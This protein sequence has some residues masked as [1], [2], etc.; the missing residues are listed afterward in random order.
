MR[1]RRNWSRLAALRATSRASRRLWQHCFTQLSRYNDF[2]IALA[3][4]PEGPT[5]KKIRSRSKFS[6][7]IEIFNLARK[8]QS[9]RLDF[10][11]PPHEN[12]AAVGGSLEHFILDRNFQSRSKSR[13][14]LIF[15]SSGYR[16]PERRTLQTG[17]EK[18]P[19]K[20]PSG[21]PKNSRKTTRGMQN[22]CFS[23]AWLAVRLFFG[24]FP[25]TFSGPHSAP[26]FGVCPAALRIF[27]G[28]F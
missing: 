6:I 26:F 5:I 23:A 10:P 8:F 3:S 18:Q 27:S 24:C 20:V 21:Q 22:N 28:Y 17:G 7:S 19:K 1:H 14:F 4:Y 2:A 11:P 25:G 13:I 15:G 16:G 9:G 12:R